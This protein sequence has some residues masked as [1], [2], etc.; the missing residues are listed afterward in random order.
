MLKKVEAMMKECPGSISIKRFP[1]LNSSLRFLNPAHWQNVF[2]EPSDRRRLRKEEQELSAEEQDP[3]RDHP[4]RRG[5]GL[6][7]KEHQIRR[8][9]NPGVV[10]GIQGKFI[11]DHLNFPFLNDSQE[12][13]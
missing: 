12:N 11:L 5:R 10:Q 2:I 8:A 9:G 1:F 7:Q 3:L 4:D 13:Q 6:P